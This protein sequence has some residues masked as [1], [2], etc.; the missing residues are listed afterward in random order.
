MPGNIDGI[1][2]VSVLR[3][4]KKEG[5]DREIWILGGDFNALPDETKD[6]IARNA[7]KEDFLRR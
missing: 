4:Y 6:A 1:M 5:L 7:Q 2:R 3:D